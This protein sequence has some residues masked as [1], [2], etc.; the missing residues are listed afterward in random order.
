MTPDLLSEHTRN[1]SPDAERRTESPA[2]PPTEAAPEQAQPLA[3][4]IYRLLE[5]AGPPV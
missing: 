5:I 2:S 1:G 4:S 3:R